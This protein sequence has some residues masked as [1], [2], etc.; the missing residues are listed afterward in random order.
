M[1]G[2]RVRTSILKIHGILPESVDTGCPGA[3]LSPTEFRLQFSVWVGLTIIV[4][5]ELN[6]TV[7]Q[8]MLRYHVTLNV[9]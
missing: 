8:L 3:R 6:Y 2:K 1:S 5:T 7:T 4:T 9:T